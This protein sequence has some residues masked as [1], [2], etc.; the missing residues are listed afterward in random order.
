MKRRIFIGD[1]HGESI[2]LIDLI[3]GL[4]LKSTDDLVFLGD[5]IDRGRYSKEV[6]DLL[7][8]IYEAL[9]QTRFLW[10]NHDLM[11]YEWLA[12]KNPVYGETYEGQKT[13]K[14]FIPENSHVQLGKQHVLNE[15]K[16]LFDIMESHADYPEQVAVHGGLNF[17]KPDPI[18]G[19]NLYEKVNTRMFVSGN[20]LNKPIIVGHTPQ[21]N[22]MLTDDRK[23]VNVDT[24]SGSGGELSALIYFPEYYFY[25][26]KS[27]FG[28]D[29]LPLSEF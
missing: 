11:F 12:N 10:G 28:V 3:E 20:P 18:K 2:Q 13:I 7:K 24:G 27:G 26:D 5:Y 21:P 17:T 8:Q 25:T 22:I 19:T 14:Q 9:P 23:M 15:Y 1:I 29:V 4:N 6:Y 16:W